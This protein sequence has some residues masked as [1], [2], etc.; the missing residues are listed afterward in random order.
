MIHNQF[1][2]KKREYFFLLLVLCLASF[3]FLKNLGNDYLWQDEAETALLGRSILIHGIPIGHDGKNSFSQ[4]RGWELG[5]NYIWKL[6]PWFQNYVAAASFAVLGEST[7]SARLP[8]ALFGM[9]TVFLTYFFSRL[10]WEDK[11]IAVI[12]ALLL[13]FSVPFLILSRQCRYYAPSAFFSLLGLY[14]YIRFIDKKKYAGLLFITASILLFHTLYIFCLVLLATVFVHAFLFHRNRFRSVFILCF[15]VMLINLPWSVWWL[16]NIGIQKYFQ[17]QGF[18]MKTGYLLKN[19]DRYIF[20]SLLLFVPLCMG[21]FRY[22]K[23]GKFFSQERVLWRILSLFLFFIFFDII[24][25]SFAASHMSFR[26]LVPLIPVSCVLAA[27]II[28]SAFDFHKIVGIAVIAFLMF[29]SDSQLP[30]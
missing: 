21:I 8:F 23:T 5:K 30:L 18:L 9:A 1:F 25:F 15:I 10:L 16:S 19:F 28:K 3:L 2:D 6:H 17:S 27:L 14:S 4:H 12:A 11:R 20:S 29:S 7:F 22:K 24:I 13:L 26:Y